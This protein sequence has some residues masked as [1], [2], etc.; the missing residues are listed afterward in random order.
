MEPRAPLWRE[1]LKSAA[2]GAARVVVGLLTCVALGAAVGGIGG[3][4]YGGMFL[5][6][7]G[8]VVGAFAGMGLWLLGYHAIHGI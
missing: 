5:A 3:Y 6:A 1:L 8:A 4:W 7:A 2:D